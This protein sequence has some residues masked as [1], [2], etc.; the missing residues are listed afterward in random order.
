M[1]GVTFR[2]TMTRDGSCGTSFEVIVE[3]SGRGRKESGS[4]GDLFRDWRLVITINA[5]QAARDS[6]TISHHL[7]RPRGCVVTYTLHRSR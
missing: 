5:Q 7:P 2:I 1:F 3:L 4:E 6:K